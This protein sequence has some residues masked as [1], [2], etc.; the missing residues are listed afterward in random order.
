[1]KYRQ[2]TTLIYLI[3]QGFTLIKLCLFIFSNNGKIIQSYDLV[4]NTFVSVYSGA[5]VYF[6]SKERIKL[7]KQV[8]SKTEVA[9]F[10]MKWFAKE[11]PGLRLEPVPAEELLYHVY[12]FGE[13]SAIGVMN[14]R[15][16][17][18]SYRRSND[19]NCIID[20]LNGQLKGIQFCRQAEKHWSGYRR[21]FVLPTLRPKSF[22]HV[23]FEGSRILHDDIVP[24]LDTVFC[25]LRDGFIIFLDTRMI[26][27]EDTFAWRTAAY[28]NLRKLGWANAAEQFPCNNQSIVG[29]IHLFHGIAHCFQLQFFIEEM[30]S[31]HFTKSFLVGFPSYDSAV[32][33]TLGE[34]VYSV[35]QAKQVAYR[36]GMMNLVRLMYYEEKRPLS[37]NVYWIHGNKH[38]CLLQSFE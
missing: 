20:G 5:K 33:L 2:S 22:A 16:I 11:E 24:E 18:T 27:H 26:P 31:A 37:A 7:N 8:F 14:L 3:K 32:A 21:E 13:P 12:G 1:M 19:L 6:L 15:N 9:D 25:E 34:P 23:Q 38:I 36:S 30:R 10:V 4:K 28:H 35:E 29:K 17:W